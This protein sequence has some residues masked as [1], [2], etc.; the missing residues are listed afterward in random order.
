MV[1]TT[2]RIP[3]HDYDHDKDSRSWLQPQEGYQS[4]VKTMRRIAEHGHN[5]KKDTKAW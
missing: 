2:R 3:K 5:H 4:I 1:M